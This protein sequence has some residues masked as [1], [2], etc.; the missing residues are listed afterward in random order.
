MTM[1]TNLD[2]QTQDPQLRLNARKP[3]AIKQKP[4]AKPKAK[5]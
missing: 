4:K 1:I 3:K 5:A 2:H